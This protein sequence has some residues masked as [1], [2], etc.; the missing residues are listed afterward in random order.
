M[1]HTIHA[2][3]TPIYFESKYFFIYYANLQ[4]D[5]NILILYFPFQEPKPTEYYE[6]SYRVIQNRWDK[7]KLC[8][9]WKRFWEST[10]KIC[11]VPQFPTVTTWIFNTDNDIN[12]MLN[13][14]D[15]DFEMVFSNP[16]EEKVKRKLGYEGKG[17]GML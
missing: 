6:T 8:H 2:G 11:L 13:Q 10:S 1:Q 5:K 12:Q 7:K 3:R 4:S 9:G 15:G 16:D 14:D 17:T